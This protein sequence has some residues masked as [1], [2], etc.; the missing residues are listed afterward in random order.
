[1]NYEAYRLIKNPVS[2]INIIK[3]TKNESKEHFLKKAKL[4]Y[5]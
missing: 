5:D 1:M 3:I 4:C 2:D